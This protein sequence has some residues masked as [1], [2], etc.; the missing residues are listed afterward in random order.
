MDC[1]VDIARRVG[2]ELKQATFHI[3]C[4]PGD[5]TDF[6][7]DVF[8]SFKSIINKPKPDLLVSTFCYG[9]KLFLNNDFITE[10]RGKASVTSVILNQSVFR[11]MLHC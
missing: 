10:Y 9:F 5:D 8:H 3:C 2:M 4:F 11:A 1:V 6:M 7:F